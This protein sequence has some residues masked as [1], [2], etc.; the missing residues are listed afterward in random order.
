MDK[1]D[2]ASATFNVHVVPPNVCEPNNGWDTQ[3]PMKT[4][5]AVVDAADV[6]D[7]DDCAVPMVVSIFLNVFAFVNVNPG[8]YVGDCSPAGNEPVNVWVAA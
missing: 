3:N 2:S 4:I 5:W 1:F 7:N 8:V 6:P